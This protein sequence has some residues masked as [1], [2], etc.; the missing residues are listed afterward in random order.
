MVVLRLIGPLLIEQ[1]RTAARQG[2]K[3]ICTQELFSSA[4]FCSGQDSQNFDLAEPIP[5]KIS[6]QLS[7]LAAELN[8]VIVA[9]YFEKRSSALYHNSAI[10]INSDGALLGVYRKTHI[11]QDP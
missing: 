3:I 2:A 4:Y 5:G 11:P 9:A 7:E 10:I 8:V 1:I 6:E